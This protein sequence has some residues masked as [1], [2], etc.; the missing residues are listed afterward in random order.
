MKSSEQTK[1]KEKNIGK[2]I[3]FSMGYFFNTYII[4]AF[5]NYVWTYYEGE[6]GLISLISLWP[7][8][9]AIANAIYTIWS[10][11]SNPLLGYYTDRP[12]KSTRRIGFHTPWIII[13]GIP[14]IFL[15][16]F[17]FTP[18]SV[19]GPESALLIII[20]YLLIVCLFDIFNSLFQTHSFGAFAAH[21][22]SDTARRRAG[23]FTQLF[24]FLANFL[25]ITIWSQ[26]IDPGNPTTF[27]IAH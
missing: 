3:L 6:L 7:I 16:L 27:I 2:T 15:F 17:L 20:Y 1:F 5:N 19:S 11:I 10:M 23:F 9:M 12:L 4:V 8:Y 13:S 24:T 26:I 22:R 18:P 14:T 21:F 25:A